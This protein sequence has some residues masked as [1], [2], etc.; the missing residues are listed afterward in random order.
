MIRVIVIVIAWYAMF[1]PAADYASTWHLREHPIEGVRVQLQDGREIDGT[2]SR[3]W[4]GQWVLAR[5]DGGMSTFD[6]SKVLMMSFQKPETPLGF[7]GAWR[8]WVPVVLLCSIFSFALAWP[9]LK[10]W[11]R[12]VTQG[13]S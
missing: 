2:L 7:W 3:N 12:F 13:A 10:G 4:R 8:S 1:T 9:W 11:R 6:E 5:T